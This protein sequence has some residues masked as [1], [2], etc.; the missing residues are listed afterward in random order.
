MVAKQFKLIV[1]MSAFVFLNGCAI[2]SAK[3]QNGTA[4]QATPKTMIIT[5]PLIIQD[6]KP[7]VTEPSVAVEP[8][9]QSEV[10]LEQEKNQSPDVTSNSQA[11]VLPKFGIIFSGG[12]AKAWA[13]IGVLKEMQKL[14]W[15]ISSVAGFE[16]G[17]AVAAL[18]AMNL[19]V[20]E[21]EWEMS[22][23]KEFDKWDLFI[24][25]AFNKKM[26]SDL[27]IPFV[28]PSLNV[29]KQTIYLLNR[30]Q[31][32]QLIPFCL[33]STTLTK[34]ISQSIGLLNDVPSLAQHL[35]A[36]GSNRIILINVLAQ[37]SKRSFTKD[38]ESSDNIQWVES[39]A[40]MAKKPAGVDDVIDIN[41][42]DYGLKDLDKRRDISNKGAD[43]SSGQLKKLADKYGL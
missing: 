17:S 36:T 41:L 5:Q 15:P 43:L 39:A 21:V 38:Y 29:A 7:S 18:Y 33:G 25:A 34:P 13:H 28:C 2:K 12:G 4:A 23:L 22:K 14:K 35:R 6:S 10:S 20:N 3:H 11:K 1:S 9:G 42:D 16:W 30:G 24:K 37:Y 40:L 19:S 31:L 8:S 27:K 26:T 32:G